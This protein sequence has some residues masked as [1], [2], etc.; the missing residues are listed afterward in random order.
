L[1]QRRWA[2]IADDLTGACDAAAAFAQAGFTASV[3]LDEARL[4]DCE[5]EL[6]AYSCETRN[7]EEAQAVLITERG[8][9]RLIE[10]GRFVLFAKIDSVLRGSPLAEVEAVSR[11][12]GGIPAVLTP[13]M[14]AQGRLVID[15]SLCVVDADTGRPLQPPS[16]IP[17][18]PNV[19]VADA[20]S[21]SDLRRLAAEWLSASNTPLFAGSAGLAEAVAVELASRLRV[22]PSE[23]AI[24]PATRPALILIGTS[25]PV[26]E[27]QIA[28]LK[29]SLP[30]VEKPLSAVALEPIRASTLV[31]L[32]WDTPPLLDA[33]ATRIRGG[34]IG[35]LIL[36]GGDTARYVLDA[37][38]AAEIVLGGEWEPGIPWGRIGGGA[39]DNIAVV[40]KSGGFGRDDLLIRIL[41]AVAPPD[42]RS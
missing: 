33:L 22:A 16:K 31:R 8:C 28:A 37:F 14:P 13:A 4:A 17:A 21:F 38:A 26:T 3:V 11:R 12:L 5:S 23:R 10:A 32:S 34:E 7:A 25:H 1:A 27:G 35:S 29:A 6:A 24:R 42:V 18:G 36:S 9:D 39:A 41:R 20:A 15:G 19:R 2:L 30:E 40:T